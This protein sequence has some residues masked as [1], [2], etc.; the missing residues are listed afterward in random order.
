MKAP[1]TSEGMALAGV[2][3]AAGL[4]DGML[5]AVWL[6]DAASLR[7]VAANA[8]AGEMLGVDAQSLCGREIVELC[9][10]PEDLFFWSE[11]ACGLTQNLESETWLR[12]FDGVTIPVKRRISRLAMAA[13]QDVF[14]VVLH[15]AS[16]RQ[17]IEGMLE[18]RVAELAATLEST[19]DG[20][21]VIDV[22]GNIRSFNQAFAAL[23]DL[24]DMVV[25]RRDDDAIFAVQPTSAPFFSDDTIVT[26]PPAQ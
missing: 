6:I 24:P 18:E 25:R 16:E 20:I 14:I 12:R 26:V 10:T 3:F 7:V 13:G 21:L 9:A 22:A 5:D 19:A 17:R 15:D 2:H 4:I 11:A 8:V 23:W 1:S